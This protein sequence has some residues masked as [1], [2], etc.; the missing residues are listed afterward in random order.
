MKREPLSTRSRNS[1]AK[2]SAKPAFTRPAEPT[3]APQ[4]GTLLGPRNRS[5][6]AWLGYRKPEAL[7]MTLH[8]PGVGVELAVQADIALAIA[9]DLA[10]ALHG[11]DA[12]YKTILLGIG[13]FQFFAQ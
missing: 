6:G 10:I 5:A 1:K 13:D 11:I 12:A 3:W 4:G 9:H 2:T 8:L 7:R